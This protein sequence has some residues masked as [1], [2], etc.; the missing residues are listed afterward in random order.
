[1]KI[2]GINCS[3]RRGKTTF[4]ALEQCLKAARDAQPGIETEIIELGGMTIR[5]C[6]ACNRC[7]SGFEC[8]IDDD[9]AQ[10]CPRLAS[11]DVRA[12]VIGTPVYMGGM[13]SQ[14]KAFL[15]RSVLFRRNGFLFRNR[16]GGVLAVGGVRNGGQELTI[17][18][19]HTAMLCHDMIIVGDGMQSAHFGGALYAGID[20]GIEKDEE[21][22]IT[23]GNLG[24]RIVSVIGK[25]L[26]K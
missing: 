6:S 17:R 10:L 12:M 26:S 20:G 24:R 5:G 14:C 11:E 4:F 9:F 19:V 8:G 15:D 25:E 16:V 7:K 22:L 21:G 1:M 3:P 23:A 2:I 13:T 18:S